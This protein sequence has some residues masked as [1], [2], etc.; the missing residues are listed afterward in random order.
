MTSAVA[1]GEGPTDRTRAR[2]VPEPRAIRWLIALRVVVITTLFLG[3][4]IVQVTSR[5]ILPLEGLYLLTLATYVL[6]LVYTALYLARIG[7]RVQAAT[8]ILG[9]V[10]VV[11]GFVYVTGGLYSPFSFLYLA[12]IAVA[13]LLLPRGGLLAAGLASIAYGAMV[14]LMVFRVMPIPP[15]LVGTHP[16]LPASRVLLQ[17]FVNIVGFLVVAL[18]VAYL[19]ESVHSMAGRLEAERRRS[20]RAEALADHVLR[21][22]G[23]GMIA[24]DGAGIVLH[25][26]PAALK[27]LEL[28]SDEEAVGRSIESVLPLETNNWGLLL[29][30]ARSRPVNRLEDRVAERGEDLGLS[31][32]PL[33]DDTGKQAGFVISFQSLSE[34]REAAERRRLQERMAAV[35]EMAARMAHEIRN[36][37]ASISGA[38]QVLTGQEGSNAKSRQLLDIVVRESRRLSQVLQDFLQFAK[39][40]EGHPS[41]VEIGPLVQDCLALMRASSEL[42]DGHV[43]KLE[44]PSDLTVVGIEGLLRQAIWNLLRNATQAMPG[45]GT[46]VIRGEQDP[47]GSVQLQFLDSGPGVPPEILDRAFEP[48]VT[49]R[50]EGTGLGLAVVYAAVMQHGGTVEIRDREEGGT[51]VTVHLPARPPEVGHE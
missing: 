12:V 2:A 23:A 32:G 43:V 48:F 44:I 27:I 39:P 35:G 20:Q 50:Q 26:N 28:P 19:A 29:S 41:T 13:A 42:E 33:T 1:A 45:E 47:D 5:M 15:N 30:R 18:L 25:A 6:T 34:V 7:T 3:S 49:G 51:G 40:G 10:L 11:T 9:D 22:I 16:T 37:L 24:L 21:S 36:P 46:L 4:M 8:Q 38:A 14:D 17:L 31:L